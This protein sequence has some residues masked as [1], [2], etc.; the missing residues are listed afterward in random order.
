MPQLMTMIQAYGAH[1]AK[2]DTKAAEK[3]LAAIQEALDDRD[4]A[5]FEKYWNKIPG[6]L[7]KAGPMS[8][9]GVRQV[10]ELAWFKGRQALYQG[11][12]YKPEVPTTLGV[13]PAQKARS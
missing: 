5:S 13:S 2:G 7:V 10:C 8:E 3:Q 11:S 6:P 12:D 1:M 9:L 4:D